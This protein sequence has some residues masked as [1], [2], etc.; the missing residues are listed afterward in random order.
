MQRRAT[1]QTAGHRERQERRAEGAMSYSQRPANVSS[2][3]EDKLQLS[4]IALERLARILIEIAQ[5]QRQEE[6]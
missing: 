1:V 4:P 2:R 6:S 3:A 5:S